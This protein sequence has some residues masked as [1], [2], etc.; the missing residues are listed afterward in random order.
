[1]T[2]RE[3][4]VSDILAEDGNIEQGFLQCTCH[5]ERYSVPV[6][7]LVHPVAQ[8]DYSHAALRGLRR[9]RPR[10]VF[11]FSVRSSPAFLYTSGCIVNAQ[12]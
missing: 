12:L 1:M 11:T 7:V 4:L 9:F 6:A 8:R 2:S 10:L 5:R 3:S